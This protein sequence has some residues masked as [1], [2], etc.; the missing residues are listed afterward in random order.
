MIISLLDAT[1][2]K[3]RA[4]PAVAVKALITP[5]LT[6]MLF[7]AYKALALALA[8]GKRHATIVA[9][10]PEIWTMFASEYLII[11]PSFV[12]FFLDPKNL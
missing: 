1:V 4:K 2:R 3:I 9:T 6:T 11:V 7:I 10:A 5:S 12:A 8:I